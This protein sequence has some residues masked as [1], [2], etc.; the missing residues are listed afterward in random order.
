[1]GPAKARI[2]S[3]STV[4]FVVL[5]VAACLAALSTIISSGMG[6]MGF[7]G[8]LGSGSPAA[9]S[10][11]QAA[12]GTRALQDALL[13]AFLLVMAFTFRRISLA[14]TPFIEAVPKRLR[15]ASVLLFAAIALPHW[16][17]MLLGSLAEGSAGFAMVDGT[18]L[19]AFA[20]AAIVFCLAHIFD[21]G[22]MMQRDA[23]GIV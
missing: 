17:G 7:F 14:E 1:M 5:A 3:S 8:A 20:C 18:I 12:A 11:Q 21:Y 23:D 22:L 9:L 6:I 15:V 16:L 2:A 19:L 13:A 4:A 10:V